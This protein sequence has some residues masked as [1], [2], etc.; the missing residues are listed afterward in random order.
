MTHLAI[1]ENETMSR[2]IPRITGISTQGNVTHG[3]GLA[4]RVSEEF[5]FHPLVVCSCGECDDVDDLQCVDNYLFT[6]SPQ[7]YPTARALYMWA[8]VVEAIYLIYQWSVSLIDFEKDDRLLVSFCQDLESLFESEECTIN[9]HLHCHLIK[10]VFMTL[11][12]H[13]L[14]GVCFWALHRIPLTISQ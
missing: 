7:A 5:V 13:M 1:L 2:F 11:G 4:S 6:C 12:H 3:V 14:L 10:S 8:K 9:M